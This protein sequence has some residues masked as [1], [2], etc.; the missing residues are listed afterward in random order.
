MGLISRRAFIGG[1]AAASVL[2]A[3]T[4]VFRTGAHGAVAAGGPGAASSR[5]GSA[6]PGT[7]GP[8]SPGAVSDGA[9]VAD[10]ADGPVPLTRS[11]FTPLVGATLRM[12]GEGDD[13]DVVLSQVNDLS[14]SARGEEDRFA[15]I[16]RAPAGR[17]RAQGIRTFRHERLGGT[18][19]FVAPVGRPVDGV[20]YE[21]VFNRL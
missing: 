17:P 13:F 11:T 20:T 7:S 6:G 10:V 2:A 19:I 4:V 1:G 14:P 5:E 12:T 16:F 18:G 3:W 8:G 21:A 15:L 9:D